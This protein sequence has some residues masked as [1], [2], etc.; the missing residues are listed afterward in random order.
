MTGP[1]AMAAAPRDGIVLIVDD[2]T[3]NLKVVG[4][5][6]ADCGYGVVIAQDGEEALR[7]TDLVRPDLILLDVMLPDVDGFEVCRR[8]KSRPDTRDIPI[9]F[10]TALADTEYK[11]RGFDA[12]AVDYVTKP[13]QVNE[14]LAR[15]DT[16]M[17]LRRLQKALEDKHAELQ[18]SHAELERRVAE[19]TSEL[20]DANRLLTLEIRERMQAEDR[21]AL[22]NFA[23]DQVSDGAFLLDVDGRI[24]YVNDAACRMTAYRHEE[25]LAMHASDLHSGW[26]RD[27]YRQRWARLRDVGNVM[28]ELQHRTKD[29]RLFFAE[30]GEN[31]FEYG[32]Q[33]Y[34]LTLMRDISAS[35]AAESALRESECKFRTLAENS[36]DLIVRYGLDCRR[37]YVNP[38]YTAFFHVS[39]E[40]ALAGEPGAPWY[41]DTSVAAYKDMLRQVMATGV[42]AEKFMTWHM[43]GAAPV[44]YHFHIVPEYGTDGAVQRLLTIG[45]DITAIKEAERELRESRVQLRELAARQHK[46]REEERKHIARELHD[47]LGQFLTALRMKI[48]LLRVRFGEHDAELTA[49]AKSMTELVDRNLQVVRDVAASLRPGALDMGLQSALEWLVADFAGHV[50]IACVLDVID[51]EV[52]LDEMN[53]TAIFRIVQESLTNV[54]RHAGASRVTVTLDSEGAFCRVTVCDDGKG[55][56]PGLTRRTSLGLLGM[57]ERVLMVGGELD[58]DSAPG[59]GTTLV[60][61]VPRRDGAPPRLP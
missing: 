22:K 13:L 2:T 37:L 5:C 18:R 34:N 42:R 4:E 46:A 6:M 47:E 27:A 58:I 16:H 20:R 24:L 25:L 38:A 19:R 43:P 11:L 33:G 50:G 26:S 41:G 30:L 48:S 31:Y 10:M 36:P 7:R 14:V 61:R 54:A 23:L 53:A 49:H 56:D 51:R 1:R 8:L 15:V 45:R 12:G 55:F 59:R 57:R 28:T 35:Q 60:V 21:L 17:R 44:H 32:G 3:A 39:V 9:I 52:D 40:D 29:G